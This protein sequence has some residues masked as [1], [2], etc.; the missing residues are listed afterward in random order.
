MPAYGRY[1]E[2]YITVNSGHWSGR[3]EAVIR[4]LSDRVRAGGAEY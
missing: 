2:L 3:H 4:D 1:G